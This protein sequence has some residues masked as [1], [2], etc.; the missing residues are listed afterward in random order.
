MNS[1]STTITQTPVL[2]ST[3]ALVGTYFGISALT[4]LAIV[5][6]RGDPSTV[7]S[8]VW[9]RGTIVAVSSL[10][11]LLCTLGAARGSQR[12]YLR[13]RLI[14]AIMVVAIAVV[15]ALPGTFPLWLKI[16]QGV[17]GLL[18][19]AVVVVVNGRRVRSRFAAR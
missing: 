13:L 15:I 4:M 3:T 2:R 10:L 18:L 12:A 16:E 14:S 8:A 19:I 17:C 11:T 5:L 6:M 7:N 1:T 9:I